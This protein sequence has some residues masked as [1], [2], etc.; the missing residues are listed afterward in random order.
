VL[1]DDGRTLFMRDGGNT[2]T[3]ADVV[4]GNVQAT[5]NVNAGGLMYLRPD[6]HPVL[7]TGNAISVDLEAGVAHNDNNGTFGV[8]SKSADQRHVYG[9]S[10]AIAEPDRVIA[11]AFPR[12]VPSTMTWIAPLGALA[13]WRIAAMV[14]IRLRSP[15][16]GSSRS[17][18]WSDRN[19]SRSPARARWIDSMETGRLMASG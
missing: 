10:N 18:F 6:A 4:T 5:Y 19:N 12:S 1:S 14:P 17:P 11:S 7:L 8:Y 9:A 2:L 13:I 16:S 3:V 15:G